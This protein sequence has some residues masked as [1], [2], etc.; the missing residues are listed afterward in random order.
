MNT[1]KPPTKP[2]AKTIE[3]LIYDETITERLKS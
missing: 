1:K 3:E 2:L